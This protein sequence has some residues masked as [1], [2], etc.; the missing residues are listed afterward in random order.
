MSDF[1]LDVLD[2][3]RSDV[4]VAKFRP[5]PDITAYELAQIYRHLNPR[6]DLCVISHIDWDAL[7]AANRHL[8]ISD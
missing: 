6:S 4:V 5:Q 1:V 7:G 2:R 3:L 8:S